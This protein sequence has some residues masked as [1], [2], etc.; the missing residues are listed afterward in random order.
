MSKGIVLA[1]GAGTRLNPVTKGVSK[2][3]LPLYDKPMVYFPIS[4]ML[5]A[6]IRDILVITT[7]EDSPSFKKLLGDGSDYGVKFSYAV[8][9][10][11]NGISCA[12]LIAEECGFLSP[13]EP[14]CLVL[15][16]NIFHSSGLS[17]TLQKAAKMA[18]YGRATIFGYYVKD[19]RRYGVAVV[20]KTVPFEKGFYRCTDIEE[21]PEKPKSHYAVIGL[22]FYP[23]TVLEKA[24]E[25]KPS[26]RGEL[27][28]TDLNKLYIE[29]GGNRLGIHL[30]PRGFTWFDAGT[31]DSL[32][33]AQN[34]VQAVEKRTGCQL[35]CLEEIAYNNG[36]ITREKLLDIAGKMKNSEYGKYLI[37]LSEQEPVPIEMQDE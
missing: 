26:A 20:D 6:G 35:G 2:Q 32:L 18:K 23:G 4:V 22:Y 33:D 7:P 16:D 36:W 37:S 5:L 13:G 34:Y 29:S 30:L 11:P 25:L 12:F 1:G 10:K 14:V 21:K 31:F 28:I 24:K 3:L 8:Q 9:E 27:E 19:P 15:G 17:E